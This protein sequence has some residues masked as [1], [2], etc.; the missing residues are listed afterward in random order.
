MKVSWINPSLW[1]CSAYSAAAAAK[2]TLSSSKKRAQ[3]EAKNKKE[4]RDEMNKFQKQMVSLWKQNNKRRQ[5]SKKE[6]EA[7][8]E[9]LIMN[10]LNAHIVPSN[11]I[12]LG[13]KLLPTQQP[14]QP[15]RHH[16]HKNVKKWLIW[17]FPY[18]LLNSSFYAW[19]ML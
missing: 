2:E 18:I 3:M 16:H 9:V 15:R 10:R 19:V 17:Y 11:E 13:I 7:A 6:E 8:N 4:L 1:N 14:H 5:R 12:G